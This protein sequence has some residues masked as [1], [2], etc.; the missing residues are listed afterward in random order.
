MFRHILVPIDSS[1][2]SE[3]AAKCALKL[4]KSLGA[5]VT[6]VHVIPKFHAFTCRAQL[7][8]SYHATLTDD[9]PAGYK[10]ATRI[11]AGKLLHVVTRAAEAAGVKCDTLELDGDQPFAA[12]V[13]AA[14]KKRCDLIV[15]AS[16]GRSGVSAVLLGSETQKVLAHSAVP[17]LVVREP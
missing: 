14:K 13:D 7:M 17:V 16:H 8:L 9:S 1:K 6:A 4:A 10:A 12:I 2:F 3:K 15:M 5:K 11:G